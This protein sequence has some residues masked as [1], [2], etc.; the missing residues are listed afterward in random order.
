[1]NT[2][3]DVLEIAWV[4][5]VKFM[6]TLQICSTVL[7]LYAFDMYKND[8]HNNSLETAVLACAFDHRCEISFSS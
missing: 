6:L 2:E 4:R 5:L 3:L 1:M 8:V 7:A